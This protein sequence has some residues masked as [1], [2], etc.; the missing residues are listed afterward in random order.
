MEDN[1]INNL[2]GAVCRSFSDPKFRFYY[3]S[4]FVSK[5]TASDDGFVESEAVK[6]NHSLSIKKQENGDVTLSVDS[7]KGA[8]LTVTPEEQKEYMKYMCQLIENKS[9]E[10]S[11]IVNSHKGTDR[12][13]ADEDILNVEVF[14]MLTGKNEYANRIEASENLLAGVVERFN[15][16]MVKISALDSITKDDYVQTLETPAFVSKQQ[17]Q[18]DALIQSSLKN[19]YLGIALNNFYKRIYQSHPKEN[20]N[21]SDLIP[22]FSSVKAKNPIEELDN[23]TKKSIQTTKNVEETQ[24]QFAQKKGEM[25]AQKGSSLATEDVDIANKDNDI[26]IKYKT[27]DGKT[28]NVSFKIETQNAGNARTFDIDTYFLKTRITERNPMFPMVIF[29]DNMK[30]GESTW[31]AGGGSCEY[32]SP[33]LKD[34]LI[35]ENLFDSVKSEELRVILRRA[36]KDALKAIKNG[37]ERKSIVEKVADKTE[38]VKDKLAKKTEKLRGDDNA[39]QKT[40]DQPAQGIKSRII[41][42]LSGKVNG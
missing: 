6:L 15:D 12:D 29:S 30:V 34:T 26:S 39:E 13:R 11:A 21:Y 23:N 37:S 38:E 3:D 41:K 20:N 28:L 22:D 17:A 42:K 35:D 40:K 33:L 19:L 9:S 24:E 16:D 32:G 31:R 27:A 5:V 36:Q 4:K 2:K 10:A 25:Y 1:I 7:I 18:K 14:N 8:T